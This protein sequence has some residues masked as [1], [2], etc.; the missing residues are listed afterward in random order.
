MGFTPM[1]GLMMG[2]RSGSVD[3]GLLLYLMR[4]RGVSSE[5]LEHALNHESGLLGVSGVSADMRE[6]MEAAER[7]N[8]RSALAVR[9]FVRRAR[10]AIGALAVTLGRVDGLVFTAGIGEHSAPVRSAICDGLEC[11]GLEL[12]RELNASAHPDAIVS[13]SSSRGAILIIATREDVM[14]ARAAVARVRS[15][16]AG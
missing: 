5:A 10:A 12:D 11:L 7:G 15:S 3:P 9:I 13:T 6:V 1:E 8:E 2:T 4:Q 14:M 16:V